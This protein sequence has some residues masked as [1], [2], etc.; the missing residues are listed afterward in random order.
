MRTVLYPGS[1]DP[2]TVGHLEMIQRAAALFDRVV[3][4]V[5]HNPNKPSGAFAV[6]ERIR[7]IETAADA[8]ANVTVIAASG[9]LVD[10]CRGAGATAV[11]RGLR[12][13]QDVPE[14]LQMARLNRQIGGVETLFLASSPGVSHISASRVREIGRLGGDIRGMVPE[15]VLDRVRRRLAPDA[16]T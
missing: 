5:M 10:V 14:E 1:F 7:L 13:M 16:S 15:R 4:A 2:I 12:E 6:D 3:V 9:L 11:V 8:L